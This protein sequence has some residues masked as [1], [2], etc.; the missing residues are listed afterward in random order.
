VASARPAAVRNLLDYLG[1]S[2]TAEAKRRQ[3]LTPA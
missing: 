3:G 2:A 1:S